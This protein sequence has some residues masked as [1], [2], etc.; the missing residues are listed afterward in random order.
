MSMSMIRTITSNV[1]GLNLHPRHRSHPSIHNSS[2]SLEISKLKHGYLFVASRGAQTGRIRCG[3][4]SELHAIMDN[5]LLSGVPQPPPNF[6]IWACWVFGS[7]LTIIIPLWKLK[8]GFLQKVGS[9]VEQVVDIVEDVAE[10]VEDVAEVMEDVAEAV[11]KVSSDV[12]DNLPKG[13]ILRDA[14]LWIGNTSKE[15][16]HLTDEVEKKVDALIDSFTEDGG[17]AIQKEA[18]V[19]ERTEK[20]ETVVGQ[21]LAEQREQVEKAAP[22]KQEAQVRQS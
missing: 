9:K 22:F 18:N 16:D 21:P 19:D 14:A 2:P 3:M 8:G 12:A 5:Y 10:A 6:P 15:V 7:I 20:I 17:E 13:G 4:Q 1:H 11:E